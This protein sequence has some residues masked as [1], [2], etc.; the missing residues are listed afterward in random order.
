MR[1]SGRVRRVLLRVVVS[2]VVADVVVGL[3]GAPSRARS[4]SRSVT[5][6]S[7]AEP[8]TSGNVSQPGPRHSRFLAGLARRLVPVEAVLRTCM[9]CHPWGDRYQSTLLSRPL[10]RTFDP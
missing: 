9:P 5:L 4:R 2:F 10:R 7:Q 8:P 6:S 3:L 1:L